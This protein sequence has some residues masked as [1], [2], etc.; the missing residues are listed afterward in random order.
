[1]N[2]DD[3]TP[4]DASLRRPQ[5]ETRGDRLYAEIVERIIRGDFSAGDRLPSEAALS[6]MFRVSRPIVREALAR[7]RDHGLV[8]SRRG[9]GSY[10]QRGP[11][12]ALLRFTP[13]G[14]ISGIQACLEFRA[15]LEARAAAFA[16]DRHDAQ[17]LS[18]IV[19]A[20]ERLEQVIRT[21]ELGVDADFEF[22][23]AVATA[24]RNAFFRQS[25]E[26]LSDQ[27]R[28]GMRVMRSLSLIQPAERLQLVQNEHLAI[29]KAIRARDGQ[30]AAAAMALHIDNARRRMLDG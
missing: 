9:S 24:S 8:Y 30:A 15:A 26:M 23:H 18:D 29:L 14:S 6:E 7:L 2:N 28:V 11:H 3:P 21:G 13:V 5:E 17:S 4:A 16:A 27:V 20:L 1:M 22:H 19:L 25:I 12:R 10:V